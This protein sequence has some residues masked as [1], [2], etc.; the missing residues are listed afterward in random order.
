MGWFI[1]LLKRLIVCLDVRNRRVTKGVKFADN[2]DIGDPVELANFYAQDGADELIFYDITASAEHRKIDI[3]MV[4]SVAKQTF[5]PF[6]VGGGISSVMDMREVILAGADK[7]SVNSLAVRNPRILTEGARAFGRQCIVLGMDVKAVEK[8]SAIPS[9][10]EVYIEGGRVATG[11]DAVKWAK[12][13]VEMGAGEICLNAIDTDG[14]CNGYALDVTRMISEA[15]AVPVIASGGGGRVEH[16]ADALQQGKADAVL[17]A[18]MVHSG[19]YRC[20]EIKQQLTAMQVPVRL[21]CPR[22]LQ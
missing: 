18:S 20:S 21:C 12:K 11:L 2:R 10:Y 17:V 6:C 15:V 1:M 5:I 7:I 13:A 3:E 16:L 22:Q 4:K 19:S 9:G 14:V 8:T